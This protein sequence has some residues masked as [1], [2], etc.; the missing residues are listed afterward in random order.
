MR[1]KVLVLLLVVVGVGL[2]ISQ[3]A[4]AQCA[5]TD[6]G[7]AGDDVIVCS[8]TSTMVYGEYISTDGVAA[9]G[10]DHL[11]NL[12][13]ILEMYGEY[14]YVFTGTAIANGDDT[15][16]NEGLVQFGIYGDY[17]LVNSGD[18]FA[19]G[20][21]TII[22]GA[23]D[24]SSFSWVA[25]DYAISFAG[26]DAHAGGD[27]TIIGILYLDKISG[28]EAMSWVDAIADGDDTIINSGE[29]IQVDGDLAFS[30][31][32]E[33]LADG[34]DNIT[35][36]GQIHYFTGDSAIADSGGTATASGDDVLINNGVV[37]VVNGDT[38]QA[39][40]GG[41]AT[42]SGDDTITNHGTIEYFTGDSA[43]AQSA[44]TAIASG[45]DT[46]TNHGTMLMLIG[47]EAYSEDG[48]ATASGVDVILNN[49]EMQFILG[50]SATTNGGTATA[51]GDDIIINNG[52][53]WMIVGDSAYTFTGA[54]TAIASGD[55]VITNN[56]VVLYDIIADQAIDFATLPPG[57]MDPTGNGTTA[58]HDIVI[59]R[60]VIYGGIYLGGGD[61]AVLI[62]N[63]AP[64]HDLMDGGPGTDSLTFE[65]TTTY[66]EAAAE[67]WAWA[68]AIV[69]QNPAKGGVMMN[70][71]W[72]SWENFE[73][74]YH[75]VQ[76]L[77]FCNA[78]P[79]QVFQQDADT[80]VVW[81]PINDT[82]AFRV[83]EID[84][85][86][87]SQDPAGT[88]FQAPGS[89]WYVVVYWVYDH[90][91]VNVYDHTGFLTTDRC[92]F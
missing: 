10:A 31:G 46:V 11:T 90:Y 29:I 22:V 36:D 79:V 52:E 58:G 50:D 76:F 7:G 38:A 77:P 32:G 64:V 40:G 24:L 18:A 12:G 60:G 37:L 16:I 84:L 21:D 8:G 2:V 25:G 45:D 43:Y 88:R 92:T 56:G 68:H 42:A 49:G 48:V 66:G 74:L 44:G 62:I 82:E 1:V 75:S 51:S 57:S 78:W 14:V 72:F 6:T 89:D 3:P 87:L 19:T 59:N 35:N 39:M 9:I 85:N 47:D 73:A 53:V 65:F 15:I 33:A 54:G 34:D 67:M 27:D 28:D 26:G 5:P 86:Q 61:D 13:D 83:A 71:V 41:N 91:Q 69:A 23:F 81:A 80:V 4:S 30:Y 17:A 20:D 63:A 70:G 55:D